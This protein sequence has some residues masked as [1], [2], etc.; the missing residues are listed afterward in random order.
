MGC[1]RLLPHVILLLGL[2]APLCTMAQGRY[3]QK[4]ILVKG[5]ESRFMKGEKVPVFDFKR[6]EVLP[7]LLARGWRIVSV[8][9]NEK[10]RE[11]DLYGYVVVER[12]TTSE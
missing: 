6:D 9:V 4:L 2:T 8:H 12:Q 11:S 10:S 1:K 3:E 5:D 7:Y